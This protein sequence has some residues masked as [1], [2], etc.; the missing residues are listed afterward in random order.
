MS[1]KDIEMEQISKEADNRCGTIE[2]S[3]ADKWKIVIDAIS[4]LLEKN[5]WL[6]FLILLVSTNVLT[7]KNIVGFFSALKWFTITLWF[8]GQ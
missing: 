7:E 6:F 1:K 5:K 4:D 8:W 2:M 3:W